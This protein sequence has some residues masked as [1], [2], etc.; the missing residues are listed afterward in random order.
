LTVGPFAAACR[1]A[2]D[3]A[4]SPHHHSARRAGN[5]HHASRTAGTGI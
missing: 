4:R 1:E 2:G 5:E 3:L